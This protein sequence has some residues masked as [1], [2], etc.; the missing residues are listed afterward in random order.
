MRYIYIFYEINLLS[1]IQ[2][3]DFTWGNS[4]FRAAKLTKNFDLDKCSCS[5]CGIWFDACRSFSLSGVW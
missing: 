5:G 1:Y 3:A 2:G 4:L